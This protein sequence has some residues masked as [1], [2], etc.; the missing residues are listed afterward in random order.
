MYK[1]LGIIIFGVNRV[2]HYYYL[3]KTRKQS[4]TFWRRVLFYEN[5]HVIIFCHNLLATREKQGNNSSELSG[6]F[7]PS[8]SVSSDFLEIIEYMFPLY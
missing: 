2:M 1:V 7:E 8:T 5:V 6:N 4:L 3:M